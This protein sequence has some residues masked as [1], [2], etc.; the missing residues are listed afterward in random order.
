V[1]GTLKA[2]RPMALGHSARG[3]H[4]ARRCGHSARRPPFRHSAPADSRR[5]LA[6]AGTPPAL[7][8][9]PPD[10]TVGTPHLR[11][12]RWARHAALRGTPSRHS[13]RSGHSARRR[14]HSARRP[15]LQALRPRGPPGA[16]L[17]SAAALRPW[18]ALRPRSH[19]GALCPRGPPRPALGTPRHSAHGRHS[20]PTWRALRPTRRWGP[21]RLRVGSAGGVLPARA[22]GVPPQAECPQ[23]RAGTPRSGGECPRGGS[24]GGVPAAASGCLPRAECLGV[25][26]GHARERSA[27]EWGLRAECLQLRAECP[28]LRVGV[29]PAGGVPRKERTN[30]VTAEP[31]RGPKRLRGTKTVEGNT[32]V[33]RNENL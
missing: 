17:G 26:P 31:L 24:V 30:T 7:A 18:W 2:L 9:T 15:Q 6:V 13:A 23:C 12:S 19:S 11:H 14:R 4:S 3:E 29:P 21:E 1:R 5:H 33:T 32:T 28:E 16:A 8:G 20:A 10:P 27:Y 25:P 22:G